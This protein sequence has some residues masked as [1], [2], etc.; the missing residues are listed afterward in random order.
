M[1]PLDRI[2]L[3]AISGFIG[4]IITGIVLGYV[5]SPGNSIMLITIISCLVGALFGESLNWAPPPK[6]GP[7]RYVY[8]DPD[9]DE[10]FDKEIEDSLG[11]SR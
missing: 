5:L 3:G 7:K 2:L 11:G 9:D 1:K 4:G 10:E 6:K 8:F